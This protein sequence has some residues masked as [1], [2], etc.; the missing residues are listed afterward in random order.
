MRTMIQMKFA[1]GDSYERGF[2]VRDKASG[3]PVTEPFEEIYFTV[4]KYCSTET[5]YKFQKRMST[6]GIVSDGDGHYT[7]Y[8]NPEDTNDLPFGKYDCDIE[9]VKDEGQYKR[10]FFGTLELTREVTY[11]ENE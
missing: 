2:L 7:L 11:S 10:T 4:K 9:L 3:E 8:I 5:E 6:G 1:R